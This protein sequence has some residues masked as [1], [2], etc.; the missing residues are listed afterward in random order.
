MASCAPGA[1]S[2]LAARSW[3]RQTFGGTQY[4]ANQWAAKYNFLKENSLSNISGEN[5]TTKLG[6]P[7]CVRHPTVRCNPRTPE[8]YSFT[9]SICFSSTCPITNGDSCP[10]GM[11]KTRTARVSEFHRVRT[12]PR[13]R[14]EWRPGNPSGCRHICL[15]VEQRH[16]VPR[17]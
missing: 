6:M 10:T 15:L 11:M 8:R 9:A 13:S 14:R 16:S 4:S 3:G 17:R 2:R 7:G 12:S 1:R 5:E